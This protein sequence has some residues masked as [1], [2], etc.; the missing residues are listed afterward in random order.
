MVKQGF[1]IAQAHHQR[2][3]ARPMG[4]WLYLV[5][6]LPETPAFY[7]RKGK[8]W[9]VKEVVDQWLSIEFRFRKNWGCYEID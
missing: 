6:E 1:T 9:T 5:S 8:V 3:K 2:I 4:E 7:G